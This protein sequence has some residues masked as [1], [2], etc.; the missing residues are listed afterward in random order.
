MRLLRD[1]I[2][3]SGL[4]LVAPWRSRSR[5]HL[6]RLWRPLPPLRG[7]GSRVVVHA[8]SLGEVNA[9]AKLV[10]ELSELGLD[11]V[12]SSTT[13]S[14]QERSRELHP[15]LNHTDW[16]LDISFCC[17]RWLD[18]VNPDVLV[19]VELEVWPTLVAMAKQRGIPVMVVNGRL[20][21]RS[22]QRS[23]RWERVLRDGYANLCR[24]FAQSEDD[25]SRFCR[26]GVP[27]DLVSV[28]PNLKWDREPASCDDVEAL[29]FALRLDTASPVVLFASTAPEEHHLFAKS[30]PPSCQAVIAPRRP[31]W[32]ADALEAFPN[33]RLRTDPKASGDTIVL[34]SLGELDAV[35]P[36]A[37]VVVMGRSFGLR[38]GSDPMGPAASGT[39]TVIGPNF[40]DFVPAVEAL[41]SEGALDV[42]SADDL[43]HRLGEIAAWTETLERMGTAG[44]P[45]PRPL[46]VARMVARN[47]PANAA[48]PERPGRQKKKSR[49]TRCSTTSADGGHGHK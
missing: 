13:L 40:G 44:V 31:E 35:F 9:S 38:H 34:N 12:C 15:S 5:R 49:C 4:L 24:V 23:K 10:H 43:P 20:S 26:M 2:L 8:V 28:H 11:V 36:L 1:L 17:K 22:F 46:G 42:L 33:A 18:H 39:P 30:I 16:P 25:A 29:R 14:G 47:R 41:R 7:S 21:E 45:S 48:A 27:T 32:F 37:D 19:L 3:L 6:R